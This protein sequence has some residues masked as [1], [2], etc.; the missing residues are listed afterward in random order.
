MS[1]TPLAVFVRAPSSGEVKTRLGAALDAEARVALYRAFVSDVLATCREVAEV[2]PELW[3][4]GDV[5]DPFVAS[6]A[7][8]APV[9]AQPSERD[10]GGRMAAALEDMIARAGRGLIIGSD[11]PTLP[12]S[13]LRR[14]ATTLE[15]AEAV[16]G[17]S[18]DGGFHLVGARARVPPIFEG[19]R[20]S[21]SF[22][23]S[24]TRAAAARAEVELSHLPPW[25]DVDT[26]WDLA[27]L[28]SHLKVDPGA[29]PATASQ[30]FQLLGPAG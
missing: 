5:R 26:P 11:S 9:K 14:A 13:T 23:L 12:A 28:R 7:S 10:L 18:A 3:V 2:E 1:P 17:P 16:I 22:A 27:L 24:D 6:V 15:R 8:G 20:Y 4:A 30:L 29:A 19:I 21:T 25:Y